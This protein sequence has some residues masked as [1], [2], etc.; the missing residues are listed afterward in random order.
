MTTE[1]KI[2][3]AI[4]GDSGVGKSSVLHAFQ[5]GEPCK[6]RESTIG[7]DNRKVSH[8]VNDK[9]YILDIWDTAGESKYKTIANAYYK[10]ANAF[11]V[12]FDVSNMESFENTI[13]KWI[14]VASLTVASDYCLVLVG[15]KSDHDNK[16]VSTETAKKA[17]I[18]L[19]IDYFEVSAYNYEGDINGIFYSIAENISNK[20]KMHKGGVKLHSNDEGQDQGSKACILL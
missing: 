9:N 7:M 1:T 8:V 12:V 20:T 5:S 15:N 18:S 3:I 17:A 10:T 2:K 14:P 16:A 6:R 11:I 19:G 13:N 4:C